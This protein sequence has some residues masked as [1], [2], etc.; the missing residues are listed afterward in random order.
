ME[1]AEPRLRSGE[2]LPWIDRLEREL[3]NIRAALHRTLITAPDETAAL[4]LVFALGWFWWLRNHR[5]EGLAWTER[6]VALGE[7]PDDPADPRYWPRMRLR[8]LHFFLAIENHTVAELREDPETLTLVRRVRS[9][10]GDEPGPEAARFPVCSGR[11]PKPSSA[12]TPRNRTGCGACSTPPSPT[13]AAT[14]GT[15]RSA[16]P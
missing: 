4:R 8:M 2:Q 7:D 11:S 14:A 16:S 13:A 9:A 15:G 12:P 1:T 6:A 3:D 5:S 10:F